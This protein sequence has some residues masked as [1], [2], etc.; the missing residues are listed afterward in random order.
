MRWASS[1]RE[2]SCAS[3]CPHRARCTVSRRGVTLFSAAPVGQAE[4]R[5]AQLLAPQRQRDERSRVPGWGSWKRRLRGSWARRSPWLRPGKRRRQEIAVSPMRSSLPGARLVLA[6]DRDEVAGFL[7][8][9][10]VIEAGQA[11]PET[12]RE[13]WSGFWP[14]WRPARRQSLSGGESRKGPPSPGRCG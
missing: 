11:D 10:R 5:A 14:A 9:A 7:V 3:I 2:R 13:L 4:H 6:A 12:V 8:E 1:V